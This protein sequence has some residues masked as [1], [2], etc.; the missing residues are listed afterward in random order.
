[1]KSLLE[2]MMKFAGEP[3]QTAGDQVRSSEKVKKSGK[4]HPFKGRLVGDS[5]EP[6]TNMLEELSQESKDKNIEWALSEAWAEFKEAAFKDTA[7]KR[8]TR[9]GSRP[10]RGHEPVARYKKVEEATQE[11]IWQGWKIRYETTPQ[12]K[13]QPLRWMVW[14]TKRGTESAHEG[15]ANTP[16]EAI[17]AAKAWIQSGGNAKEITTSTVTIDFNVKFANEIVN[18]NDFY[19]KIVQGPTL[20][21]SGDAKPGF[22]RSHIRTQ[23]SKATQDTT[24]LP[25]ISLSNS[26]ATSAGLKAHGRY[27]LGDTQQMEDGTLAYPLIYQSTVQAKGDIMRLGKPG[28]TVA[29]NR[30]VS[31]LEETDQGISKAKE[32]EFHT[33]LD[34]LVHDTFGRRKEEMKEGWGR[35]HDRVSLPDEPSTY[36]SGKGQLQKEYEALYDQLV[37]AS[38]AADTIEGEVLRAASKIVYRHYNDGDEFNAP[39]FGQ[40]EEFIGKVTSYDDLAHKATE[41]ALKA[42]GNYHPNHGWDSL[43]V[44]EY[45]PEDNS[46]DYDED[47]GWDEEEED[48]SWDQDDNDEDLDE[49]DK[50]EFKSTYKKFNDKVKQQKEKG[51]AESYYKYSVKN[52]DG[53]GGVYH[54]AEPGYTDQIIAKDIAKAKR[55]NPRATIQA[56]K[57][58][59]PFDWEAVLGEGIVDKVRGANYKRLAKRS[60]DKA[61]DAHQDSID[62]PKTPAERRSARAEFNKQYDKGVA[63]EKLAK[64][65]GE[66]W[67]S[68]PEERAPRERDPDWEYDQRRQEKMDIEAEKAQAQRPQEQ[69]YTLV[70]RGPNYEANYAFP[71]E[72]AT[73]DEAV[74]ARARLMADPSTPNPRDIGISKRTR[75]LDIKEGRETP[76][77]DKEDYAAKKK[78][79]QD[80]Q[81]DPST[82]QD[83]ELSVEV[84]RRLA[85]LKQ[86]AKAMGLDE[87]RA[88][89]I[90]ARKLADIERK[91]TAAD[92]DDDAARAEKAKADYAKYVAKMKKEN[93]NFIP[94]FKIDEYGADATT[95]ATSST[96]DKTK[97]KDIAQASQALKAAT[98]STAPAQNIVKAIDAASQG[99]P[100]GQQDMKA[101]EPLMK[102][103]ATVASAPK[104]AGQF[105]SLMQQVDREQ[106]LQGK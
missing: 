43:D 22:K 66:G 10:S 40:L 72:Y 104:L 1:M 38:G 78:A 63:R 27:I 86:Q 52:P 8:T 49:S 20:L 55:D 17:E 96:I 56:T 32:T 60:F 79:L 18:G 21:V 74:A 73:Q 19:A 2:K 42:N 57:D 98:G 65:L 94:M 25:M 59:K 106:K 23:K 11:E 70:G 76:L 3:D 97:V 103:I 71:G 54:K 5:I 36:W 77:R 51:V 88:H 29:M 89:K 41:F 81:S 67:E 92:T 69:Y 15:Q 4:D 7:E 28:L 95:S 39:S 14:H 91:P 68:G 34:T 83:L 31:G 16:Q 87:S 99:K 75:Y 84:M 35:G 93:P 12:I 37:P 44:M 48:T 9:K 46:D 101:I 47:D 33:K 13:G 50:E 105:R 61:Y 45:G 90:L 82:A 85:G 26:E 58:G 53:K 64:E 102:D 62:A 100:V 30:E 80:I 24:L 6:Q